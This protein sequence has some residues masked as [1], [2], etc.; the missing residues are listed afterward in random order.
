MKNSITTSAIAYSFWLA[1]AV[2]SYSQTPGVDRPRI[3]G[4]DHVSFYTTQPEGV[5]SSTAARSVLLPLRRSSLVA[6]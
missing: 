2:C 3:L 4:I 6:S 5:K 1:F